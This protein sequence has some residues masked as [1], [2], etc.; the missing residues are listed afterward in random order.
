M[1]KILLRRRSKGGRM[2]GFWDLPSPD[3]LPQA[4]LGKTYGEIRHTITHHH[5]TLIV[6]AATAS[7]VE[8]EAFEWYAPAQLGEIP[9]STT[10]RKSL[11]LAG[12]V[13]KL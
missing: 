4:R 3:D 10:A 13:Y 11:A 8:G 1:G 9:L 6:R 5:Y 2:A 12:I 7:K